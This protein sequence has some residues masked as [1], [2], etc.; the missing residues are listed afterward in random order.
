MDKRIRSILGSIIVIAVIAGVTGIGTN[1]FFSDTETSKE[2]TFVAGIID[3]SVNGN[4]PIEE[5]IVTIEDM[6]PCR[7][8]YVEKILHIYGNHA[9]LWMHIKNIISSQGVQTEPESEEE[10]LMGTAANGKWDIENYITYD[11]KI[12]WDK[13]GDGRIADDEY[14][15]IFYPEDHIKFGWIECAWISLG[16]DLP[17]SV[18]IIVNQS[19]HMQADVTN[20]AQGDICEFTEEFLATQVNSPSPNNILLRLENKDENFNIVYNDGIWALLSYNPSGSTFDYELVAHCLQS[21]T[22]YSL[23]YYADPYPGDHPGALLGTFTTDATGMIHPTTGSVEINM[24]LPHTS[25]ANYPS[26]AKIWLVPS[27]DYDAVNHKIIG[28]S[29]TEYL[30]EHN[31]ITYDDTDV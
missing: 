27:S 26:G 5:A 17:S 13:N 2:N 8:F 16:F 24:D 21:N 19:F 29:P 31:L 25:D 23:I 3:L 11:L 6:K 28:W 20:W 1:S 10:S 22:S 30:F 12:G 7:I 14:T 15:I 18:D 9:D 4:N